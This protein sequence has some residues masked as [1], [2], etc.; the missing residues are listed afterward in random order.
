MVDKG[1]TDAEKAANEF[2]KQQRDREKSRHEK[3]IVLSPSSVERKYSVMPIKLNEKRTSDRRS[4]LVS[5]KRARD[6][7][8]RER[9]NV[10][11]CN[12]DDDVDEFGRIKNKATPRPRSRSRSRSPHKRRIK[13]EENGWIHDK[14]V[15]DSPRYYSTS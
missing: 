13:E 11:K 12:N 5:E 14:Y 1:Y 7:H 4:D 3:P 6:D 2:R 8:L 15:D 10:E 9:V